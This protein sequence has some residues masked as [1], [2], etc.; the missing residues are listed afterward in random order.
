MAA[1]PA[2]FAV[3]GVAAERGRGSGAVTMAVSAKRLM[4]R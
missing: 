3:N 4:L 1:E 2:L